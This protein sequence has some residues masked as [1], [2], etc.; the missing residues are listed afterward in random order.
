LLTPDTAKIR[1]LRDEKK[2]VVVPKPPIEDGDSVG[3]TSHLDKIKSQEQNSQIQTSTGI[4]KEARQAVDD[5]YQLAKR[6][7]R[8]TVFTDLV[9]QAATGVYEIRSGALPAML[10]EDPSK[11]KGALVFLRTSNDEPS[12]VLAKDSRVVDNLC[13][14]G[15]VD[16]EACISFSKNTI[17]LPTAESLLNDPQ[18]R[19]YITSKARSEMRNAKDVAYE[20]VAKDLIHE[21][22]HAN[23]ATEFGARVAENDF[24]KRNG[25]KPEF[26]SDWDII[27]NI[28]RAGYK[29]A[30]VIASYIEM[31]QKQGSPVSPPELKRFAMQNKYT[32]R[33]VGAGLASYIEFVEYGS[34]STDRHTASYQGTTEQAAKFLKEYESSAPAPGIELS[35]ARHLLNK[36]QPLEVLSKASEDNLKA[37]VQS[38]DLSF[39][40]IKK[41]Y[42]QYN[43]ISINEIR[44]L[45][46]SFEIDAVKELNAKTAATVDAIKNQIVAPVGKGFMTARLVKLSAE[47]VDTT[48]ERGVQSIPKD[49]L[50]KAEVEKLRKSIL[51]GE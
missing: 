3:V 16:A 18:S 17:V 6:Y 11:G 20:V 37:L 48:I 34:G 15:T 29:P 25:L 27:E 8:E 13:Q 31:R 50:A 2:K 10:L 9:K 21:D 39:K 33:D 36:G 46:N 45:F 44:E 22:A 28:Q 12:I 19:S 42:A 51:R 14:S 40:Q 41:A 24:A 5:I 23:G 4:S 30:A 43:S 38:K 32:D 1:I 35:Q 47:A 7:P 49:Y 26:T